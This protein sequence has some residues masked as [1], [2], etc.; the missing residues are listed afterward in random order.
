MENYTITEEQIKQA[1]NH[2]CSEWKER[3]ERWFPDAF[4]SELMVGRWAYIK[5]NSMD[6]ALIFIKDK[7][8][9]YTYGFNHA[10]EWTEKYDNENFHNRYI[11]DFVQ[12]ATM[13]E[14][15]SALIEEA[16]RRYGAN[17][18][19]VEINAHAD[20]ANWSG[21]GINKGSFNIGVFWNKMYSVN[22][23]I[24]IDGVWAE[25]LL[26]IEVTL[27]EIAEKFNVSVEQL[28][29]KNNLNN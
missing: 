7:S 13:E 27:R 19:Q 8:E 4:K 6:N 22:G 28:I 3:I 5:H 17:W 9:H 29:I 11:K 1:H 16:K 20:G 14:V 25:P 24:Y 18:E 10:G 2:A 26:K 23:V 15:E 21:L 12:Y